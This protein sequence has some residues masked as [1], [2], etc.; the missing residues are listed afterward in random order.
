NHSPERAI[1]DKL[2]REDLY[3]RLNVF[4]I[5]LP[6]LRERK[7]D[8]PAIAA[9][10][11]RDLN[12]KHSCRVTNLSGDVQE[13]FEA[14]SW[15]GNVRELRNVVE[16]AV[17]LAGEREVHLRHLPQGLTVLRETAAPANVSDEAFRIHFGSSLREVED[18]YIRRIL[19]SVNNDKKRAAELLGLSLRT[20]YNRTQPVAQEKAA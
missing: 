5:S 11:I 16:R 17:I 18:A 20:L 13:R 6:A 10:L 12:K 8:I 3:Y 19:S 7:Q 2:L 14:Y 1:Q 15:P 9:A 4:H